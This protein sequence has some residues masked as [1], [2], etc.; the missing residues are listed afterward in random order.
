MTMSRPDDQELEKFIDSLARRQPLRS[1]PSS[2][3]ARVM[4]RLHDAPT[5]A[6][7]TVQAGAQSWRRGFGGWPIWARAGFVALSIVFV[8]LVVVAAAALGGWTSSAAPLRLLDP[9]ETW[10]HIAARAAAIA[11]STLVSLYNAVPAVW[12]DVLLGAAVLLYLSLFGLSTIVY[13]TL[14][15][16]R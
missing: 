9:A 15:L 14:Y 5:S 4:A 1:A 7:A 8:R 10:I 6:E 2:L 11:G 16:H 12:I 13:R 3:Q